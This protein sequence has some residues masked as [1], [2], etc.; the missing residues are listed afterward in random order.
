MSYIL[1]EQFIAHFKQFF[2]EN[3]LL[4]FI[5]ILIIET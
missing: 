4:L 2:A 3:P 1:N 5:D